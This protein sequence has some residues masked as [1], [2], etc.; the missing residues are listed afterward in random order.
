MKRYPVIL[1]A[2][3]C[4]VACQDNNPFQPED[5]TVLGFSIQTAGSAAQNEAITALI[6]A[7]DMLDPGTE[8]PTGEVVH[9]RGQQILW[10]VTGEDLTGTFQATGDFVFHDGLGPGHGRFVMDLTY[11]CVGTFEGNW[12]G[13]LDPHF[14]GELLGQGNAGCKGRVIKGGFQPLNPTDTY[15]FGN[16]VQSFTGTLH[17]SNP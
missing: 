15:P 1:I 14:K 12:H 10:A 8:T 4:T 11:P 6:I 7:V 9:R 3:T 17:T 5:T 13:V 16:F 2:L